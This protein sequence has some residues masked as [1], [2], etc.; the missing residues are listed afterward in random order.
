MKLRLTDWL[1]FV[2]LFVLFLL[3]LLLASV[4][5]TPGENAVEQNLVQ[6]G[7]MSFSPSLQDNRQE[8]A[9]SSRSAAGRAFGT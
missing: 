4:P 7:T 1:L 5:H 2:C 8:Q 3:F 9:P 6:Q